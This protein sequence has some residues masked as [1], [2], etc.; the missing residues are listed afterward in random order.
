M[1]QIGGEW[2]MD[3]NL[4][5]D[6]EKWREEGRREILREIEQN[7]CLIDD[8]YCFYC[9]QGVGFPLASRHKPDC[10]FLRAQ[11]AVKDAQP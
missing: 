8:A 5:L 2:Y 7:G 6:V 3:Q 10:L 4:G 9:G 11:Q 1:N